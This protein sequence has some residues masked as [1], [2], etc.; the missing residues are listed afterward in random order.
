[1]RQPA[2]RSLVG[3]FYGL[4]RMS[5]SI[6]D[7]PYLAVGAILARGGM[8]PVRTVVL[9]LV[10]AF[11]GLTA[12]F[13]LNDMMDHRVDAEKMKAVAGRPAPFD[14]DSVGLRHPVAQGKLSF[15]AGLA[16]VLFWGVLS[17][18]TAWLVRPAC[19]WLLL[20]AAGLEAAYCSLLRVTPWKTVLSGCN[21]AVGGLAGLYAV[22]RFPSAG[23]VS[24][25]FMW[26]LAWETGCRN[27]ANDWTDFDEDAAL[28]IKTI[29]IRF[30]LPRAARIS[31]VAMM[32]VVLCAA[33]FPLASPLAHW[34]LYELGSLAA[35][36][37]LLVFPSLAWQ[38]EL[39]RKSA[40]AFFNKACFYP[41]AVFASLGLAVAV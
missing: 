33:L 37:Y 2:L 10:S 24:L 28:G 6:L 25:Y 23:L 5:H 35:A 14:L 34:P 20:A 38:R 40:L 13:G 26:S 32:M 19:A 36:A 7:V 8:P 3:R 30:G 41:L 21:V 18:A 39:S 16:W 1:M 15:K 27:I 9:G 17:F 31:F 29:A 4:S 11:A 12:I 22:T